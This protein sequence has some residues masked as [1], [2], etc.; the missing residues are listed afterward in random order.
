MNPQL[1]RHVDGDLF[2]SS[3][4]N[5]PCQCPGEWWVELA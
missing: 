3:F 5:V 1:T 4:P 2:T